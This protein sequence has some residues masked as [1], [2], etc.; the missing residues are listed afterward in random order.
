MVKEWDE[1]SVF[2]AALDTP[3]DQRAAYLQAACPDEAA[4]ERIEALL[5][6][7]AAVTRELLSAL[8]HGEQEA[9]EDA[10]ARI[11]EFQILRRIG[12]G[13]MGVVYL[14]EDL[15]LGRK[16]ALKVLAPGLIGSD[17]A[18][19][20]FR[21]EA[22]SSAAIKHPGIVPVYKYGFDGEIHYIACEY[23][24][25]PTLTKFIEFERG[26]RYGRT[27]T[28]D[29]RA[30]YRQ[31]AETIGAVAEALDAAH[32]NQIIHRDVKPSNILMDPDHGPRLTDFGIA[33]HLGD[34]GR[35]AVTALIGSCHYMSPE[36]ASIAG[37]A[38]DQRSDIFSLGVVLYELLTLR[39]PF[40]GESQGEILRAVAELDPVRPKAL[41]NRIPRDLEIICQKSLEKRPQD[42]YQTA[43]HVAA[44]LRCFLAGDPILASPLRLSRRIARWIRRRRRVAGVSLIALLALSLCMA[45]IEMHR[46]R[47]RSLAW[48]TL[49]TDGVP[50]NAW[51]Q[52]SDLTSLRISSR[53]Q[54]LGSL[55][56]TPLQIPLGQYRLT[57]ARVEDGEYVE[58]NLILR[59]P[60]PMGQT[61]LRVVDASDLAGQRSRKGE[62]V[63][64]FREVREILANG[65]V[66]IGGGT[67]DLQRSPGDHVLLQG[68][69]VLDE[70][71]IDQTEV[72][73]REYKAFTEATGHS[74]PHSWSATSVW[75]SIADLPVI[76]LSLADAEAFA[77]WK[78]KRL[79]SLWEWQRAARGPGAMLFPSGDKLPAV[80]SDPPLVP[81]GS[82]ADAILKSYLVG[83]TSVHAP[84]P[85]D[86]RDGLW[87]T[88]SN[89]R[90]L[91]GTVDLRQAAVFLLGR[92]WRQPSDLGDLRD[93]TT[94]PLHLPAASSGFRCAKSVFFLELED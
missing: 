31:A 71:Y 94:A 60:G 42:R 82:N 75:E 67:T 53:R 25:G 38:V 6:H 19:A 27:G 22:R 51:L 5:E 65:M 45:G 69:I 15:I 78:G 37:T 87:H 54:L 73:N 57:V 4:R 81:F 48:V 92:D 43:G 2:L 66:R 72:S 13:G 90:E 46:E 23:V 21:T 77:R 8:P 70:F 59:E 80:D 32:R 35:S 12:E 50:C 52:P 55:G 63:G 49:E 40:N 68:A 36:Q 17:Q 3:V 1:K 79:P 47:A 20:R 61:V 44:D 16:V 14:A 24:D 62:L 30:W 88:F 83:V 56:R 7:H 86:P 28:V 18:L 26:R 76:W 10:P 11:D 34:D 89:V 64:V 29:I 93:F 74:P 9:V 58:F 91:S 41:D 84:A 85:W 39:R 33:K